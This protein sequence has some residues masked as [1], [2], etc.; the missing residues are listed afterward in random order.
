MLHRLRVSLL[1][2]L[3]AAC[4][5]TAPVAPP[6]G[7]ASPPPAAAPASS[8]APAAL[9]F[10]EGRWESQDP[11]NRWQMVS[12]WNPASGRFE[13]RLTQNGELSAS[14]G[15]TVG[16]LVWAATPGPEGAVRE[17]Q[18]FRWG[19]G[20]AFEWREGAVDLVQSAPDRLVTTHHV[21]VR[22]P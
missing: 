13:G 18:M 8:A 1:A 15:F 20:A 10:L 3:L 6:A 14:V 2:C 17:S 16:E 21:F 4:A 19:P 7:P 9:L 22:L 5:S 12:G 11:T